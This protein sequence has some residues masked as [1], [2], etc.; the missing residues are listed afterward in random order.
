LI[1]MSWARLRPAAA[2]IIGTLALVWFI[3]RIAA[4]TMS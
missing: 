2:Y 3:E 1:A 4:F